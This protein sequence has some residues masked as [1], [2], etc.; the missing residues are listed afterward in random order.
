LGFATLGRCAE[1][2]DLLNEVLA[3]IGTVS[4]GWPASASDT[5]FLLEA[6]VL[7]EDRDATARF[8]PHIAPFAASAVCGTAL[9]C[10]ARHLGA[11]SA[12]LGEREQAMR[13]YEQALEVCGRLRFRPEIALTHLGIAELLLGEDAGAM[14]RAP[15]AGDGASSPLPPGYRGSAPFSKVGGGDSSNTAN[16]GQGEGRPKPRRNAQASSAGAGGSPALAEA[17]AGLGMDARAEAMQHL[18]LAIAEL[19]AMKMQ[20]ALERALRHKEVLKA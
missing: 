5:V 8:V 11:A 14:N 17:A 12:L 2:R 4:R 19:R 16:E 15:T 20:P 6:A 10:A 7:V 9:T 3:E 1:A 18:D 13:Y